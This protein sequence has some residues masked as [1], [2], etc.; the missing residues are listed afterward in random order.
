DEEGA[1]AAHLRALLS[2]P[3]ALRA[4]GER[5]RA[6]VARAHD[7][8]R[9]AAA[10]VAACEELA[11]EPPPGP[12]P[13]RAPRP[14]ALLLASLQGELRVEPVAD[15]Q[16]GERRELSIRLR[17]TGRTRWLA[18]ARGKGGMAVW[19]ELAAA[20]GDPAERP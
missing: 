10:M 18:A 2:E 11:E 8:S 6:Y 17:N 12:A 13:A 3:G 15:W 1:L 4:M 20:G 9:A 14:S 5:A 19:V 7:P 16:P